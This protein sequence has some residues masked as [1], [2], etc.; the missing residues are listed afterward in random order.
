MCQ[1]QRKIWISIWRLN[2]LGQ[3][4]LKSTERIIDFQKLIKRRERQT[5]ERRRKST[6]LGTLIRGLL[7]CFMANRQLKWWKKCLEKLIISMRNLRS[8]LTSCCAR[9]M[10]IWLW[11]QQ[12][13][14]MSSNRPKSD[15]FF[16]LNWLFIS[17][18]LKKIIFQLEIMK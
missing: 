8:R 18:N 14:K 4:T 2:V 5:I 13:M 7:I 6:K 11:R 1:W 9:R 12:L 10:S 16:T 17:I 15:C 3:S